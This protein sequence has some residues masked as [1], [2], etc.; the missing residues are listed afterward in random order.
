MQWTRDTAQLPPV[1]RKKM[2]PY[3][4]PW[5]DHARRPGDALRLVLPSTS[6][7]DA[8]KLTRLP[9]NQ[10]PVVGD[11][12]GLPL[13]HISGVRR[14]R[15]LEGVGSRLSLGPYATAQLS[16]GKLQRVATYERFSNTRFS[17]LPLR[18]IGKDKVHLFGSRP[19]SLNFIHAT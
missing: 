2:R 12:Q 15:T 17:N 16:N 14:E 3:Y 4:E 18:R 5:L 1:S 13:R 9:H 11:N 19:P 7:Y 10:R 6:L 8:P